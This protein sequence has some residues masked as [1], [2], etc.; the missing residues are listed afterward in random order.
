MASIKIG[1]TPPDLNECKTYEIFKRELQAW[2]SVTE[3]SLAKQG[4]FV[5]LSLP[6]KSKF[7]NDLRE[8]VFENISAEDLA[9]T[10]GLTK[11]I[12]FLDSELGK[13]A[14]DD[15]I[16]KWDSFDNCKREEGQTLEDFI[17]D[18]EAKSSRVRATGATLPSEILAYMLMKRSGLTNVERMLVLSRVDIS[19]KDSLYRDVKTHMTNILGK[20]MKSQADSSFKLEPAFLV[21]NEDVLAAA[22]YY[23]QR[24]GTYPNKGKFQ[25]N[26]ASFVPNRNKDKAGRPVNPKGKDGNIMTCNACGSYRHL[27]RECQHSFEKVKGVHAVEEVSEH[28]ESINVTMDVEDN[29]FEIERFVLFTSDKR[30]LSQFT[31]EAINA[32]ALDTC[33]TSTVAGEKW[34]KIYLSSLPQNMKAKVQGPLPGKKSFQFGNQGILKSLAFYRLPV[35]IVGNDLLVDVDII[36]SDIPM[37]LS[38][39]EMKRHKMILYMLEDT[40]EI[41]GSRV[42]LNTTSAGHYL[43]PLLTEVDDKDQFD[44]ETVCVVDLKKATGKDK[45][46]AL[47]KIHKQFGHRPKHVIVN[48]LKSADVWSE[49]MGLILDEISKSCEGCIHRKR[50][51]DRPAVALSLASEFNERVAIDLKVWKNCYI[52][53]LVDMWSRL[54]IGTVIKRKSPEEVV[55]SIFKTWIAHY[56]VM[57]GILHDNGG[58]FT[59]AEMEELKSKLNII[60][61]TTGAESPWQNGLCER[62]HALCDNILLRLDDDFPRVEL[63]TKVAWACMAKNC[64]QNVYGYSPNQLVFGMNP[65]MPNILSDGPPAWEE[66]TV[67]EKL[68]QHLNVLHA[69]RRAFLKSESCQ[70]LK[71]ALKSKIRTSSTVYNP[72][73]KVYF[74]REKD[75]KW[76]GP[77]KVIFQDGKVIFVR[78]GSTFV[79]VSA[80]RLVKMD[81]TVEKPTEDLGK[82]DYG[83]TK[84]H[85]SIH[86]GESLTKG[87]QGS[88]SESSLTKD[89]TIIDIGE[90]LTKGTQSDESDQSLTK[91]LT[92]SDKEECLTKGNH[93]SGSDPSLIK[94]LTENDVGECL[95]KG[96]QKRAHDHSLTKD[97]DGCEMKNSE[98]TRAKIN[99]KKT[100]Q[101]RFKEGEIWQHATIIGRSGKATG[102]NR[103]WYNICREDGGEEHSINLENTPFELVG[104]NVDDFVLLMNLT[105]EEKNSKECLEAKATE[106]K[107]LKNFDTYDIVNDVGQEVISTTWVLG[108][109]EDEIRARLVARGFEEEDNVVKDSPTLAKSSLRLLLTIIASNG[110]HVETTDIKS[111]FLQGSRL[112]RDVYV[113]PP[114]EA[115]LERG[116]VWK[117]KKCLYGL[118]DASRQW[119]LKVK[120]TLLSLG[121]EQSRLDPG[122]F[123]FIDRKGLLCGVIGLHV[124]DFIH[125]GNTSF[126]SIVIES[127]LNT[128]KVGK[129]E[130][131]AFMYTGFYIHQDNEGI[132]LDQENYTKNVIEVP[133]INIDRVKAKT[134]PLNESERSL[135]RKMTGSINWVVRATRPDLSF[136]MIE[137]STKFK[138]GTVEDLI[139]ARK[140]LLNIKQFESA[141]RIPDLGNPKYWEI[142]CYTDA[143]LG[144]LNNGIDSAGGH[145]VF[146]LNTQTSR[147]AVLDWQANKIKRVVRS[148]LAAETLSLC[149]GLE[150]AIFFADFLHDILHLKQALPVRGVID[151]KSTTEAV[152]S[153]TVVSD[154]RLRRDIAS[155][156]EMLTCGYV[157]QI[158]WVP[159]E[160]QLADVL[161]KRGVNGS[162]LLSV[163]QKGII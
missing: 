68:A 126:N 87:T 8:R 46:A 138:S 13:S 85:N 98:K 154:K 10:A 55:N 31:A 83:L 112:E 134:E 89:F 56:G 4:N 35:R 19:K 12:E 99:L 69:A 116:K 110:W 151:N 129:N 127:V 100:D 124:D 162:K 27:V 88:M 18:F 58:E 73:D 32:A 36:P 64:L 24:A 80:N 61:L 52:L 118:R 157:K 9:T 117:L 34:L 16:E 93:T 121:C 65:R 44:P 135:L 78:Y 59:G 149:E 161:T 28:N 7:G 147:V 111:A 139:R 82:D 20:C 3:L 140:C 79:R 95:T 163:I 21:Q 160:Q 146:L 76:H 145:I 97:L 137:L 120:E 103:N 66:T 67:S 38:K 133:D 130:K 42:T 132:V 23:R 107:K 53:Y 15:A 33:C 51:P 113:K 125:A 142:V 94:D 39:E 152:R 144:N 156:K 60:S 159:G 22:G 77:G 106:L 81:S 45:V 104:E 6:N 62:N 47:D 158:D 26:K 49:D 148:T 108:R 84:G 91:D 11:V 57:G 101:I 105:K 115:N 25:K 74:K 71:L 37:L 48:L 40:A 30:E 136:E 109:K 72:G 14:V 54:T 75:E 63:E 50:N 92:V 41:R 131:S 29:D 2:K 123:F 1:V 102:K 70:K 96:T 5:A 43:L 17:S 155:V 150:S 143:S 86:T 153:T 122:V 119:Y 114:K 90:C 128:F 141:I